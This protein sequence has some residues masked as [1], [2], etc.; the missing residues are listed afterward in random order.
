VTLIVTC[1]GPEGLALAAD[2]R[3]TI[4]V[5]MDSGKQDVL[6][7]DTAT[8]LFS[9]TGQP[10]VGLLAWGDYF[11]GNGRSISGCIPDLEAKLA[12]RSGGRRLTVAEVAGEVSAFLQSNG[13]H[14]LSPL[15]TAQC[16]SRWRDSMKVTLRES[17]TR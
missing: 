2:S 14:M 15:V 1:K 7:M 3:A 10:Y 8:K 11:F 13:G 12:G 4:T 17:V 5:T 6:Y 9:L 16:G